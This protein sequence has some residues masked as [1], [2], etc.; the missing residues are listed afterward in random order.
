[1]DQIVKKT[2]TGLWYIERSVFM[3]EVNTQTLGTFELGTQ[4]RINVL[5]LIIV[6]FQQKYRQHDQNIYIET[7]YRPPVKSFQSIIGTEKHPDS[8]ILLNY[9]DDDHSQ[10]Y[11]PIKEAFR[12]ITKDDILKPNISH[13]DFRPTNDGINI[14]SNL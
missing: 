6:G 13:H 7:L 11:S 10:E 12:A 3:K 9:N 4:E 14:G 8:A 1:M 2:P 5:I